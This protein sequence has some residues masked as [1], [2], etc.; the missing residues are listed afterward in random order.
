MTAFARNHQQ[1]YERKNLSEY[2][3]DSLK[4]SV[5]I[6]AYNASGTL[7]RC[8]KSV[9]M[10]SADVYEI[11]VVDDASRL[12]ESRE[13]ELITKLDGRIRY[14]RLEQN[15]GPSCARNLGIKKANGD[16]IAFLDA[17]DEW[18]E[19][20]LEVCLSEISA[21]QAIWFIGHNNIIN[22]SQNIAINDYLRPF[23]RRYTMR[24]V[25][26]FLST[27]QF[28]PSCVI[29]RRESINIFFDES[30]RRS[31]DFRLWAELIL[32]GQK[33]VKI[34]DALSIR[35]SRH[36]GQGGLSQDIAKI[37]DA[38]LSTVDYLV[39]NHL[40][41]WTSGA[42]LTLFIRFKFLRHGYLYL[43]GNR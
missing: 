25:D 7:H 8:V 1:S 24:A 39:R 20:K 32:S 17:D 38:H 27:S 3:N 22:G 30:I 41:S 35:D 43:L 4:V 9:L 42:L 2:S 16:L 31:E 10:Q 18:L 37:C 12:D 11:I 26:I 19:H 28:A 21:D 40:L 15:G 13:M 23:K 5:V 6:P 36:I 33:L 34:K 29:M 14:I